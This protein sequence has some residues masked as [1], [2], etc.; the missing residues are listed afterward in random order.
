MSFK[1]EIKGI[2]SDRPTEIKS[3]FIGRRHINISTL[4]IKVRWTWLIRVSSG[5]EVWVF[6]YEDV[7]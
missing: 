2:T 6:L 3:I 1:F 5:K 4:E 7:Q